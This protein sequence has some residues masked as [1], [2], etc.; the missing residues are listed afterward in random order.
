MGKCTPIVSFDRI[1]VTYSVAPSY[2]NGAT[3]VYHSV[4][5]ID[6][7]YFSSTIPTVLSPAI[8]KDIFKPFPVEV[9]NLEVAHNWLEIKYI[10]FF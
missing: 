2:Y 10:T 7:L 6:I 3:Y 9:P 1:V 5:Y 4:S 8:Q